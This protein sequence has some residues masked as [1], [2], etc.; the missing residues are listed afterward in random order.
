[1][2]KQYLLIIRAHHWVKN[3]L[4]F[5]PLFLSFNEYSDD[6]IINSIYVFISFSLMASGIYIFNDIQ[7]VNLDKKNIRT[8]NRP[9][10]NGIISHN[11]GYIISVILII[12]S[13]TLLIIFLPR[14][15]NFILLYLIINILYSLYLKYIIFLDIIAVSSGFLIRIVIGGVA[16]D[17]EQSVWTL[18]IV[19][20]ASLSLASGKRLGQ[21]VINHNN[22]SAKW[23]VNYLKVILLSSILLTILFY[24][25]FSINSEVAKR[26]ESDIIWLS[27][28]FIIAIF[29]RYLV[30]SW[31]GLYHGDPTDSIMKDKLLQFLA[32]IWCILIFYIFIY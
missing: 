10:A 29:L 13:L 27:F 8:K 6:G 1:M 16:S 21:L 24:G 15:L 11:V 3:L 19:S 26:H 30:I 32:L 18:L 2:F 31:K 22:L 5:F 23:N 17:I 9:I 20:F 7:D 12:S 28:P 4:I 14:C 25:L